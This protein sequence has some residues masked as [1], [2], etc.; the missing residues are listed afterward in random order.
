MN[1]TIEEAESLQNFFL[2]CGYISHEMHED[3]HEFCK[4]LDKF[5]IGYHKAQFAEDHL[6][7]VK[8]EVPMIDGYQI[9]IPPPSSSDWNSGKPPNNV[10]LQATS[11]SISDIHI[12]RAV[13]ANKETGAL[14]HWEDGNGVK[15]D[16]MTFF[17]WRHISEK[18][19]SDAALH[20]ADVM[21][22]EDNDD[23]A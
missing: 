6:G 10:W 2:N 12:V 4:K 8:E 7:V 14:P 13:Y 16:P 3:I 1:I 17:F 11:G 20:G 23:P 21:D 18:R 19:D 15:Y 5:I 22:S 9:L